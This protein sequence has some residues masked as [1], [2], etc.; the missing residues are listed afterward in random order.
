MDVT[1]V[2][3]SVVSKLS[4]HHVICFNLLKYIIAYIIMPIYFVVASAHAATLHGCVVRKRIYQFK[5]ETWWW[6]SL[7]G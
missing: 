3:A 4:H 2:T 7:A 5:G 1:V 6:S